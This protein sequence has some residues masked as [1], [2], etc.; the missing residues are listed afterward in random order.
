MF[1]HRIFKP[2]LIILNACMNFTTDFY[3]KPHKQIKQRA[4]FYT[5]LHAAKMVVQN[6]LSRLCITLKENRQIT[7]G[8]L[9]IYLL[10]I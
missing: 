10:K 1:T 7:N 9:Q 2:D 3:A 5:K 6:I 8:T 4:L